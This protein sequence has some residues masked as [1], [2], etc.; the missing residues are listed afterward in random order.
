[1]HNE[2]MNKFMLIYNF[3]SEIEGSKVQIKKYNCCLFCHETLSFFYKSILFV[4][5]DLIIID[6]SI[7]E[8]D[9][10]AYSL[11][12]QYSQIKQKINMM[13]DAF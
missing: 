7:V 11:L 12:Q 2:R 5:N 13:I 8:I 3:C 1:M 10:E 6:D 4:N 9:I